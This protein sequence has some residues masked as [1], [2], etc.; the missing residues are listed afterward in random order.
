MSHAAER[1]SRVDTAWLRMDNEVNLMMI[2]GVWL[3]TPAIS[4]AAL[5]ER[6]ESKLLKYER[7]RHKAVADAMGATWVPDD[8]FDIARHVVPA[9][10]QRQ[11]GESERQALQRLCGELAMTPLDPARPLW[12]FQF[13]EDYEGGSALV[14]RVHHCIGDGIALISVMMSITDGGAEP[15][16]RRKREPAEEAG[17]ADWLADAVLKPLTDLTI[18]AI[19]MYGGGMAKSIDMLANPYQPLLGS[20]DMARTGYKVLGDVAALAV[21]PDDSPTLLKGKPAGRKAV[22]WSEPMSLDVVK[23]IGKGLGCSVNDVLLGCVAGAIGEYL[24]GRGEDPAGKE[25]RAMVPVNLRPLDKAWQLGNRFGLAPLV[26]PIG[27]TNPVERTYAVH[28]RMNELKGSYQPLLA[29]AVLA[30]SGLFIKPVQDAVL[31]MFAKKATAVMTNVPGPAVPLKFC[32]ST[33][34]QTMFWVPA[35]GDIGVGVSILSYGGGVQFGLITDAGLCPE[36]QQIIE[37]FEPE[38]EKLLYLTLMLP[39]AGQ[40]SA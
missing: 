10:L 27:I 5:R 6:I 7:F 34:R 30:M 25:I 13:I 32:G 14:A 28:Q 15:P 18:K 16:K 22:A 33:L 2:V 23:S 1:M 3:L 39:W 8:N 36:P 35:S 21:M 38:F 24:R 31:G 19:G 9:T 40:D 17:E 20:M 29:F 37:R 26:L 12:Q 4:L 11:P